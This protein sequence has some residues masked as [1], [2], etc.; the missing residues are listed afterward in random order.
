MCHLTSGM[1][2]G[3]PVHAD[4][5]TK[6]TAGAAADAAAGA[7]AGEVQVLPPVLQPMPPPVLP[8]RQPSVLPH[9]PPPGCCRCCRLDCRRCHF[10]NAF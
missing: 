6:P 8:S 1:R 7:A 5:L 3:E 2:G 10:M 4:S 9:V